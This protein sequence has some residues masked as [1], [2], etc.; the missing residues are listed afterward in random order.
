MKYPYLLISDTHNH[1]W[2]AFSHVNQHGVNSRLEIILQESERAADTLQKAGGNYMFHAGDLFHVRG[3]IPP[4]VLNPTLDLYRSITGNGVEVRILS[5][6]H[7]LEGQEA[8]EVGS[9]VTALTYVGAVLTPGQMVG[10]EGDIAWVNW[11]STIDGLKKTIDEWRPKHERAS[12]DLIIHAPVDKVIPGIPDH[13]LSA[14]DLAELGF[15]RVFAGHY[16]NHKDFGNGVYSIGALTHQTWGDVGSKAG[17]LLVYEDRVEFHASH[18]PQFIDLPDDV[19]EEDLLAIVDGNYVR[20][21]LAAPTTGEVEGLRKLLL[22]NGAKG[23]LITSV[24]TAG[25]TAKREVVDKMDSLEVSVGKY[26]E[27]KRGK[28]LAAACLDI[29]SSVRGAA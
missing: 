7:D 27:T 28:E 22:D 29:L 8:T 17:F 16:H 21:K 10:E 6:N 13:G 23:V 15:R 20:A 3:S 14:E 25:T 1:A 24:S 11:H 19:E 4:S 5:G 26:A 9:A 2:D 18:A 12:F